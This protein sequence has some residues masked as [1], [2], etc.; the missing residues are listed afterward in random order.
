L[1]ALSGK[2]LAKLLEEHGWRLARVKG[3]HHIFVKDGR[4]E[5]ISVPIHGSKDLKK[6]LIRSILKV[7]GIEIEK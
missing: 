5:V 4:E 7:A 1:K 2:E 6:G 3:S